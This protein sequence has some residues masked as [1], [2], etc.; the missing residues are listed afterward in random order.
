MKSLLLSAVLGLSTLGTFLGTAA[1]AQGG[2][3]IWF[4]VARRVIYGPPYAGGVY[5]PAPGYV[6][7]D[8]PVVGPVYYTSD[9]APSEMGRYQYYWSNGFFMSFDRETGERWYRDP[10]G[11]WTQ[12]NR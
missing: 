5:V 2:P 10:T 6:Y 7:T 8:G 11:K 12:L 3:L 1:P 9:V 4:L